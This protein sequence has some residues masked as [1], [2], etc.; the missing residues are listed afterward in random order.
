MKKNLIKFLFICLLIITL[1]SCDYFTGNNQ[2]ST[3]K[4][5]SSIKIN[6]LPSRQWFYIDEEVDFT[7]LV[8]K[9]LGRIADVNDTVTFNGIKFTVVEIDGARITKLELYKEPVLDTISTTESL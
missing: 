6:T 5:E 8:V 2:G 4:Q 3:D 7:G 9:L 1:S